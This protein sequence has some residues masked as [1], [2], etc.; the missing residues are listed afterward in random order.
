MLRSALTVLGVYL[1]GSFAVGDADIHSD[2][3]FLVVTA[4]RVNPAAEEELRRF[5]HRLPKRGGHWNK[6]LESRMHQSPT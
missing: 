3:D 2:C 1:I 6:H 4:G 5:H